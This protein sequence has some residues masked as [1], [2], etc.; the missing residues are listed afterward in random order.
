MHYVYVLTS[1]VDNE[2]YIGETNNVESRLNSHNLG[3]VESTKD[4][5]PLKLL[6]YIAVE[7]KSKAVKLEKYLKTGSGKA[8]LKKRLI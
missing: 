2:L 4:R 1:E 5:T 6:T 3:Y 7:N 8:F